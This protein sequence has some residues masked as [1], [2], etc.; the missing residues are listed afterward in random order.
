MDRQNDKIGRGLRG[1]EMGGASTN[2]EKGEEMETTRLMHE[3]MKQ[4]NELT[5][6]NHQNTNLRT[7]RT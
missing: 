1:L 7:Q 2:Y 5:I 4:F 6:Q 3:A